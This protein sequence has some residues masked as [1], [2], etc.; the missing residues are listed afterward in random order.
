MACKYFTKNRNINDL[1]P[2]MAKKVKLWQKGDP[3]VWKAIFIDIGLRNAEHQNCLFRHGFSQLDGYKY[4]S[5]HQLGEAIDIAFRKAFVRKTEGID[6]IY[7]EKKETW[8]WVA[9]SA[10]KYGIKWMYPVWGWDRPH[11]EDDG[12]PIP[13]KNWWEKAREWAMAKGITNGER[14]HDH[15]TRAELWETLKKSNFL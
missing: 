14:P 11:F 2:R 15:L 9:D 12:N 4:L 1:S 13:Q 8:Q 6:S 7:P 5:K 10:Q 3:D